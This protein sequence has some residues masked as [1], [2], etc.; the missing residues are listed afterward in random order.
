VID[1]ELSEAIAI[2]I[3]FGVKPCPSPDESRLFVHSGKEKTQKLVPII[4]KLFVE[5]DEVSV[6]WNSMNLNQATDHV[7]AVLHKKNPEL[8]EI[9][10]KALGWLYSWNNR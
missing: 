7:V 2:F 1:P 3:G 5:M 8:S 10:L 6:D 9:A 4:Q